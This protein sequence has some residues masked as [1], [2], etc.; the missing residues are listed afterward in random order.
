MLAVPAALAGAAER[1]LGRQRRGR[2]RRA[3]RASRPARRRAAR[4]SAGR[5]RWPR[6][7]RR[8]R[9]RSNSSAMYGHSAVERV[10]HARRAIRRCRRRGAPPSRRHAAGGSALPSA[11][12]RRCRRARRRSSA[13]SRCHSSFSQVASAKLRSTVNAKSPRGSSTSVEVEEV[14]LV[15]QEGELVLVVRA[16][17]LASSLPARVSSARA[18][19]SR[20]SA[21][22]DSAMSSSSIGAWPHHSARRCGRI[23][24]VSPMRSRY[25]TAGLARDVD[26]G[27]HRR[28][29]TCGRPTSGSS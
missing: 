18:W 13:R 19:P 25:C 28:R 11:P 14:A 27:L 6:P 21:M 12:C 15:A 3:P 20:S 16:P 29:L 26:R 9:R 22:L 23:R 2:R 4:P 1:P 7:A 8:P 24:Q 10:A 5:G 17:P